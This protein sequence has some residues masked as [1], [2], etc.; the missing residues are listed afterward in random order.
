MT[1]YKTLVKDVIK[2]AD[3]LMEVLDA[4]FPDETRNR[5]IEREI[6]NLN[7]PFNVYHT[8]QRQDY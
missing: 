5:D 7:K 3:V 2:K 8:D 1:S 4:R 6:V